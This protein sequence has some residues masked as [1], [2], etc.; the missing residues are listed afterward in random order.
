MNILGMCRPFRV[1]DLSYSSQ[2]LWS[3]S[4]HYMTCGSGCVPTKQVA[5]DGA[6]GLQFAYSD[7]KLKMR[8]GPDD[9]RCPCSSEQPAPECTVEGSW[10]RVGGPGQPQLPRLTMAMS[11]GGVSRFSARAAPLK[12]AA[13]HVQASKGRW[14][15]DGYACPEH[16]Q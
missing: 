1:S 9:L 10:L 11:S 12:P 7:L 16:K 8:G 13:T 2:R 15:G 4:V 14:G 6:W 3:R 5:V